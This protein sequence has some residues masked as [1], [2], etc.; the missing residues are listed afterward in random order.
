MAQLLN[1]ANSDS[2]YYDIETPVLAWL[3]RLDFAHARENEPGFSVWGS[4]GEFRQERDALYLGYG[5]AGVRARVQRVPFAAFEGWARLTGAPLDIDG[6]DE[7]AAHWRWRANNPEA[8]ICG[9][10]GEPGIPERNAVEAEG[11][12][13]LRIRPEIY[14]R[15]R[16]HFAKALLIVPPS[17][18]DY[19]AYVVECCISPKRRSR[20]PKVRSA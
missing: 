7:F 11:A 5:F 2:P 3:D 9:R 19:A 1:S 15:W 14:V 12:Q 10:F 6:L 8:P 4:H 20:W 16:D 13:C 17:L 18:D